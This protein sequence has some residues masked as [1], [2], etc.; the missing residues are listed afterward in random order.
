MSDQLGLDLP[1]WQPHIVCGVD[2]AGRG[3]LFGD[4]V[5]AAVILDP[6]RPIPG[7]GDS[8][9]LSE[10]TRDR[11]FD[12]IWQQATA[13]AVG[14]ASVQEID[15][16][17]ILHAS[18]LAM[19]RAVEGL[20]VPPEMA[21]IDGNRCP[22]LNCPAQAIVKG[23][24]KEICIGAASIIAKVTRDR[25]MKQWHQRYPY[26]GLDQHKGYPTKQHLLALKEHGVSEQHRRS[27]GPVAAI[28]EVDQ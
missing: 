10:K 15:Q 14:R 19:Q 25:E 13:V 18:M 3:P 20:S 2:E 12:E 28:L 7:L 26:Y 8:K 27:F 11:L 6:Q 4:V 17:N 24:A 1:L 16:L 22:S 23:D 5:A 21:L 9:K